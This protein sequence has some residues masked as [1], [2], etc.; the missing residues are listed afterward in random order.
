MSPV[1]ACTISLRP[2]P[3]RRPHLRAQRPRQQKKRYFFFRTSRHLRNPHFLTYPHTATPHAPPAC[4]LL[5]TAP[6]AVIHL[7]ISLS[8]KRILATAT[9]S[10]IYHSGELVHAKLSFA[11]RLWKPGFSGTFNRLV[12]VALKKRCCAYS[13]PGRAGIAGF[14]KIATT[15]TENR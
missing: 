5:R 3:S 14:W 2:P 1:P 15:S 11:I 7:R 12:L 6:R 9:G 13:T 4:T 10:R 8:R